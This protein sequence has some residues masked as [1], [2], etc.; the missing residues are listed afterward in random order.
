MGVPGSPLAR[1][2]PELT[3]LMSATKMSSETRLRLYRQR[4]L[5]DNQTMS[6]RR[7]IPTP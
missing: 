1:I 7:G 6:P 3:N 4:F 2:E 5:L